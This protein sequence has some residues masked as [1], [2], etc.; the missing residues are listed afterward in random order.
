MKTLYLLLLLVAVFHVA[1]G[2]I[3]LTANS[4]TVFNGGSVV[5]TTS[6]LLALSSYTVENDHRIEFTFSS[7]MHSRFKHAETGETITV[8]TQED[9]KNKFI[10]FQHDGS[11][12][13][14]SFDV[15][16]TDG[17]DTIGP[18]HSDVSFTNYQVEQLRELHGH[19]VDGVV[20]ELRNG[21]YFTLWRNQSL[22]VV[23]QVLDSQF[24]KIGQELTLATSADMQ[25]NHQVVQLQSG[26][27]VVTWTSNDASGLGVFA[28]IFD[29]TG[30]HVVIPTFQVNSYIEIDQRKPSITAFSNGNF[31][32][33]WEGFHSQYYETG[34]WSRSFDSNGVPVTN[35]DVRLSP[36]V[37]CSSV[38][39]KALPNG[40]YVAVWK[41][42]NSVL[43][44]DEIIGQV[45]TQ[46]GISVGSQ[47]SVQQNTVDALYITFG[48]FSLNVDSN[49][50]FVSF[51]SFPDT[52]VTSI[53]FTGDILN[54]PVKINQQGG[55]GTSLVIPL[56]GDKIAVV[57]ITQTSTLVATL[58]NSNTLSQLSGE[59]QVTTDKIYS[60]YYSAQLSGDKI[61][62]IYWKSF[63]TV[64]A[65]VL[66]PYSD[67]TC[68]WRENAELYAPDPQVS[69]T[70]DLNSIVFDITMKS[71]PFD[72]KVH[73]YISLSKLQYDRNAGTI[74]ET[75]SATSGIVSVDTCDNVYRVVIDWNSE[76]IQRTLVSDDLLELSVT[77]YINYVLDSESASFVE[78]IVTKK[79]YAQL[80]S[81]AV[82][83]IS[84]KEQEQQPDIDMK[85]QRFYTDQNKQ[86]HIEALLTTPEACSLKSISFGNSTSGASLDISYSQKSGTS[87]F[88]IDMIATVTHGL[89]GKYYLLVETQCYNNDG[90]VKDSTQILTFDLF[91]D[92]ISPTLPSSN[93]TLDTV[94]TVRKSL[95][96]SPQS[97]FMYGQ[98]PFVTT[99]LTTSVPQLSSGQQLS[100][101]DAY[102]CCMTSNVALPIYDPSNGDYGC[103]IY[104]SETMNYWSQLV[105]SGAPT[106]S[107]STQI[108][109][110]SNAR[111]TIFSFNIDLLT[112][113]ER[114]CYIQVSTQLTSLNRR[115]ANTDAGDEQSVQPSISFTA[116]S[117]QQRSDPIVSTA[118]T[119]LPCVWL[120]VSLLLLLN[121]L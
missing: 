29:S 33:A 18:V 36:N 100:L 117:I 16:V 7:V 15:S 22:Y 106:T 107:H 59:F 74:N 50:I 57:Y 81:T 56:S 12:V 114:T 28:I 31:L 46:A 89:I 113:E 83:V 30:T 80:K 2:S 93:L 97:E 9:I 25:S 58:L 85:L 27:I 40:N 111:S 96:G 72:S 8:C 86:I 6:Q 65:V 102:I 66:K 91:T 118:S 77:V 95:N 48:Q 3:E 84:I 90:A 94:I 61:G 103:S 51:S 21:N 68:G 14:P 37:T 32:I 62:I 26:N 105:Q 70:Y 75:S 23:S 73:P 121:I 108:Y 47:F 116:F 87:S 13:A 43:N 41:Q 101:T 120:V 79:Y 24:N 67:S 76:Y 10:V 71:N 5:F 99:A 4:V 88:N 44:T 20:L 98:T 69:V 63:N 35:E 82:A 119:G 52:Y 104:D 39:L 92:Y 38:Q 60:K 109:A 42:Y 54:G 45:F 78:F 17:M 64:A 112:D 11:G 55:T 53:S 19:V 49:A 110:T 115:L 34:I 1:Y